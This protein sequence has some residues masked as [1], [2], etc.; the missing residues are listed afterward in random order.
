MAWV[1]YILRCADGSLYTGVTNDMK[2]RLA[3]HGAGKGGAYTR[4]RLPV[5]LFYTERR[6]SHGAALSREATIKRLPRAA[7]LALARGRAR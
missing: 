6:R 5:Q 7:K 3:T 2:R 4:S 1:V